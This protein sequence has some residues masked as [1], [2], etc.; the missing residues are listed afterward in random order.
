MGVAGSFWP[1]HNSR[2]LADHLRERRGTSRRETKE[3]REAMPQK[4]FL[5][6]FQEALCEK[7]TGLVGKWGALRPQIHTKHVSGEGGPGVNPRGNN[8]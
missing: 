6:K 1:D 3:T 8:V 7:E 4:T 2:A 5:P